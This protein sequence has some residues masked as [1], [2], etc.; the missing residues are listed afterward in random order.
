MP[1]SGCTTREDTSPPVTVLCGAA[2]KPAMEE[3][4]AAFERETSIGVDVQFGGS[5]HMLSQ[6]QMGGRGDL[7]I[8]GSPDYMRMARRAGVVHDS[9]TIL[10]Y[11][12]PAILVQ[13][14]N[15]RNIRS[16]ADL[17]KEG[18]AVGSGNP[19]AVCAGLYAVELLEN[20][21]L[22]D[23]VSK[24]V[25][26]HT[27]SCSKTAAVVS[28]KKV[29]AVL[30][31]RVFAAWNPRRIEA[32]PIDPG[33]VPRLGY[34]PAAI[35]RGAPNP[36]GVRR[37]LAFLAGPEGQHIFAKWGYLAT[38]REARK[39]APDASIGGRYRLPDRFRRDGGSPRP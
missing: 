24:N 35:C 34:V 10:A 19:T 39:H 20:A 8:P 6:L 15:P 23:N 7:Y 27:E 30:G 9:V 17:Q 12:V 26:V 4:A 21:G 3:C 5:G 32:V 14:D 29:D 22:L 18:I 37:F 38:K 2:S 25:V 31:W 36:G 11:L 33:M 16:L 28:L 13:N 1:F